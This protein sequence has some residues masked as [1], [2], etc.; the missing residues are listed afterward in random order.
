MTNELQEGGNRVRRLIGVYNAEGSLRGE[1]AYVIG[2][3]FGQ[4][5][6]ALCDITHG[7]LRQRASWKECRASLPVPFD[8]YH[9]DDQPEE[10]RDAIAGQA[11]AVVAE[12][13]L[14]LRVL[15]GPDQLERCESSPAALR[16]ALE[17]AIADHGLRWPGGS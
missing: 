1:L 17:Q 10:V 13:D 6:C 7:A 8:T 11:P 15:L 4:A 5:H 3:R 9:L 14:G 16:A 2:S 12:T